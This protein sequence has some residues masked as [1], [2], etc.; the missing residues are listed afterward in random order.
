MELQN[1]NLLGRY[2]ILKL[3]YNFGGDAENAGRDNTER[4]EGAS[5]AY[6]VFK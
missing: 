4:C 2:C 5:S 3:Y 1:L 6:Y